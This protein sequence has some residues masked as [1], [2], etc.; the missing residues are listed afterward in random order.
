MELIQNAEDN[1]YNEGVNPTLE[2]VITSDDITG[3]GAP[4][5]LLIFNNEKGFFSKNIDSICSVGRSTKKGNRSSGYIGE[6]GIGFKSVFLVTAQP[7][8]F[9]NGYQIRFN[10]KP[11]PH[12]SLGYIVPEWV[13]EK[14]TLVDIKKI[15]GAGKGSLRTTTI[16]LPLKSDK[17]EPVK[18]KLSSFHPEVL[19]FLTKIRHLSVREVSENP[20]QNTVTDVSISSEINFVTRKNMNAES[21][22]IHLSAEENSDAEKECSYYMWKQK[23]PVRPENAVERRT[24]VE[25]WVVTLAFPN[26]ERLHRGKSSPGVYAFLPTGM[27]TNFP[28]IIQADFVLASSRETILLDNK[29][30]QGILDCVPSAFLDAFKTLVIGSVQAP[31]SSLASMF[32]FLPIES[33]TFEKFN[34]VRDKIKAKLVEESIVPIETYSKQKHFYKPGEVSRLLP[35]FWNILTKA[36]DESVHLLNLSSHDG[37]KILSSSFDKREYYNVLN[38]LGVKSVTYGWYAK[39]IQSSDLVDGVSE[40]LYVQLLLFVAKYWSSR[41][42]GTNI[43]SI[44]LIKCVASDGTLSSF[45]LHE[46]TQHYAGGKRVVITDSSLLDDQLEQGVCMCRKSVFHARKHTKIYIVFGP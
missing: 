44:P 4:A 33:S 23:F 29:W 26:Q 14:P 2:F 27:V 24:D 16:V 13:E 18:Q 1:H 6:K 31:V 37:R 41:F 8:V 11:C 12:C 25:E 5:T 22:T 21:Y 19:L 32:K 38:F 36:R 10:E 20:K 39:C 17:V 35:E 3:T 42:K 40:D 45:S 43:N 46:C 7:Y 15:Y 9:S 34:Y 28:F 30:N